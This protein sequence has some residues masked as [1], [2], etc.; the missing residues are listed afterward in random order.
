VRVVVENFLK[1]AELRELD[2]GTGRLAEP[3]GSPARTDAKGVFMTLG[4][5]LVVFHTEDGALT[6]RIG[7]D[8]VPLEHATVELEGEDLRTL[9]VL[10]EGEEVARLSYPSPIH[11]FPEWDLS[12]AEEEDFDLGLFVRNVLGSPTRQ[13]FLRTKWA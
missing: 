5:T 6:L 8:V 11:P 3:T 2:L 12:M 9:R 4:E 13:K 7:D 1:Q 10:R